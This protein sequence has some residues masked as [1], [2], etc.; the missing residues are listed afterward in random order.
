MNIRLRRIQIGNVLYRIRPSF[1]MSY[2]RAKVS[3]V[4]GA[5]LLSRYGVPFWILA[6][7]FG[8]NQMYWYRLFMSLSVYNLVGT[9]VYNT[10]KMPQDILA[11]EFHTR[12]RGVK[13]YIATVI[14]Q[15]CFLGIQASF[16]ANET[17]LKQ[18]YGVF[19]AEIQAIIKDFQPRTI[20]TS[21]EGWLVCYSKCFEITF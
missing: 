9:T 4:Q 20:N 10:K 19:K 16:Q 18:A 14:S 12:I 8:R 2:M 1:V 11:D 6:F 13:T 5:L 3:D 17:A 15:G 7:I 21:L